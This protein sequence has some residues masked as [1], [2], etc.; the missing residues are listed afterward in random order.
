MADPVQHFDSSEAHFATAA[1]IIASS[2]AGHAA[3]R[4]VSQTM[5]HEQQE[6]RKACTAFSSVVLESSILSKSQGFNDRKP[7]M[8]VAALCRSRCELPERSVAARPQ[9]EGLPTSLHLRDPLQLPQN[10]GRHWYPDLKHTINRAPINC[11]VDGADREDIV[12]VVLE[13]SV[14]PVCNLHVAGL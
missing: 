14:D 11:K 4:N 2:L 7:K 1:L 10:L 6:A 9:Q 3:G 13:G 8:L 12:A 5:G